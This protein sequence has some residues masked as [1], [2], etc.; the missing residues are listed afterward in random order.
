MAD[1]TSSVEYYL[2]K[3]KEFEEKYGV[4]W[5][6]K[7]Y[8]NAPVK[9]SKYYDFGLKMHS[10][11]IFRR[12]GNEKDLQILKDALENKPQPSKSMRVR[13]F[14]ISPQLQASLSGFNGGRG[15][16]EKTPE[17]FY[18]RWLRWKSSK[19]KNPKVKKVVE[20]GIEK[21]GEVLMLIAAFFSARNKKAQEV[22]KVEPVKIVTAQPKKAVRGSYEK[23]PCERCNEP[24]EAYYTLSLITKGLWVKCKKCGKNAR[25]YI[26]GLRIPWKPSKTFVKSVGKE[27]AIRQAGEKEK[28]YWL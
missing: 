20:E 4:D 28:D 25:T 24:G 8:E 22:V 5:V 2:E 1:S 13:G 12:D 16:R 11:Y 15:G 7:T 10:A 27:E 9:G 3:L 18:D 23:V 14:N 21:K 17:E 26:D 19:A 6:K